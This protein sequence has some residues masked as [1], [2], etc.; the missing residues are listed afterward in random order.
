MQN[1]S[2][3]ASTQVDL[4]IFLTIFQEKFQDFPKENL[5]FSKSEKSSKLIQFFFYS[6]VFKGISKFQNSEYEVHQVGSNE[7]CSQ[8]FSFL[9]L[10]TAELATPQISSKNLRQCRQRRVTDGNFFCSNLVF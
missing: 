8:N 1:F 3:L 10:N 2:F 5:K 4:D 6:W 7:A 9:A